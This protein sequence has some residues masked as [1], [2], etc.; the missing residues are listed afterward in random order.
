MRGSYEDAPCARKGVIDQVPLS[1]LQKRGRVKHL[2]A[3]AGST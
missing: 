1:D 2:W 3:Q